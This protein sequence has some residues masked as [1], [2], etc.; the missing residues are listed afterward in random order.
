MA[1]GGMCHKR[2]WCSPAFRTISW[3]VFTWQIF[4]R[5]KDEIKERTLH[6]QNYW[7]WTCFLVPRLVNKLPFRWYW[8]MSNNERTES[9][10][11][12]FPFTH[13]C[14]KLLRCRQI[15]RM[16]AKIPKNAQQCVHALK[17]KQKRD[18]LFSFIRWLK[19]DT[20]ICI[21]TYRTL[22]TRP[23]LR[24]SIHFK[25]KKKKSV[26]HHLWWWWRWFVIQH[27]LL[28]YSI[29]LLSV[30]DG[31][32]HDMD[33]HRDLLPHPAEIPGTDAVTAFD[34]MYIYIR[35]EW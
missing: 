25:K 8:N 24:T 9:R 30:P 10:L 27:N 1:A 11:I 26:S 16:A 19:C 35:V 18:R 14:I 31:K 17:K 5:A 34:C 20:T 28:L 33:S 4:G 6:K 22:N 13:K 15:S 29:A 2:P 32:E 7:N 21:D 3:C 12:G 23:R